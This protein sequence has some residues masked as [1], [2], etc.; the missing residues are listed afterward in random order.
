MPPAII[1][2]A[3]SLDDEEAVARMTSVMRKGH[4]RSDEELV[5][6]MSRSWH[7]IDHKRP[8]GVVLA[9][10]EDDVVSAVKYCGANSLRAV[11]KR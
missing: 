9:L 3:S 6:S 10:S 4:I 2:S 5:E 8:L 7:L 11:G 1:E